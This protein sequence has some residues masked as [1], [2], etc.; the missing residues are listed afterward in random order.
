MLEEHEHKLTDN[1]KAERVKTEQELAKIH[2]NVKRLQRQLKD[3]KPTPEFIDKLREMMEEIE[4]AISSFKK[5]QRLIYEE[6][7]KEEKKVMNEIIALEKKRETW[8]LANS[9]AERGYR[10]PSGKMA[11]EKVMV[12]HLPK[13]VLEFEKFL[14]HTGGRQGGWDDYDHQNF[15]KLLAKQ[16]GKL[17][18]MEEATEYIPGRTK[19]DIQQHEKW[20]QEFLFLEDRKKESIQKWKL[21]KLQDKDAMLMHQGKSKE[22]LESEYLVQAEAQKEKLKEERRRRQEEVEAW[23]KQKES[24]AA[25]KQAAQAKEEEERERRQKQERQRQLEVKLLVEEY[26]QQKKIQEE[27]LRLEKQIQ[28]EAER[29]ERQR[30]ASAGICKFQE[31][32]FHKLELKALNKQAKEE[33]ITEREKR[34]AKLKEKVEIHVKR[35]ASRLCQFTKGWVERTKNTGPTGSGPLLHIPH[36]AV[37]SWRQGL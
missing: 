17:T 21:K 8:V 37:P 3:V 12:S 14:Q 24:E 32:D 7:I 22:V 31:R 27:F 30:S 20:Y 34:L 18:C 29:E 35:D 33:E 26:T 13:E 36:R 23:R 1:R 28:E 6:L 19:E 25:V 5:E 2:N 16:R 10:L 15:L 9:A 4:N 11:V